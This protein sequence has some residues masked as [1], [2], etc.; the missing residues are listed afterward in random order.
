MKLNELSDRSGARRPRKRIGRGI[1]SGSGKTS[2]HGHKGQKARSGV[3]IKGFEGGQMPIFRRLP[4][5]GFWSPNRKRY[6]VVNVGRLQQAIDGA[7]LDPSKPITEKILCEA[8]IVTHPHDGI[9]L[10]AK[11]HIK[12]KIAVEV[13]GASKAAIAAVEKAGG[14]VT[15]TM[16]VASGEEA[17]ASG[18][19]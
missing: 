12:A 3:A 7:K 17:G 8:G 2:G 6:Q 11:G 4:R 18:E 14:R 16:P 9:R 15:V 13:S 5:R 1:G 10:L 19:N